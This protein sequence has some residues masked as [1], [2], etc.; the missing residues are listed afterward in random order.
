MYLPIIGA[1]HVGRMRSVLLFLLA[2]LAGV[3]YGSWLVVEQDASPDPYA[4]SKASFSH[5]RGVCDALWPGVPR[6]GAG[7]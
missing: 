7:G 6:Q 4:T 5:L 1:N 3:G 2:A